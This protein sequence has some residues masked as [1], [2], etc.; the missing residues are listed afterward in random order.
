MEKNISLILTLYKM[1]HSNFKERSHEISTGNG[2][3]TCGQTFYHSSPR[4]KK[5]K[6]RLHLRFCKNPLKGTHKI[7]VPKKATTFMEHQLNAT[8]RRREVHI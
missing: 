8:M 7:R 5:L 3:C 2:K 6:L 1:T 4:D